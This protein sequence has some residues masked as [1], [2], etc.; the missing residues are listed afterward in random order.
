MLSWKYFSLTYIYLFWSH[1]LI[2]SFRKRGL[3]IKI[4]VIIDIDTLIHRAGNK[5]CQSCANIHLNLCCDFSDV[6]G[7][8]LKSLWYHCHYCRC[9]YDHY[10]YYYYCSVGYHHHK[11]T[12]QMPGGTEEERTSSV[13]QPFCWSKEEEEEKVRAGA[14][15]KQCG[16]EWSIPVA[17]LLRGLTSLPATPLP[18]TKCQCRES[19]TPPSWM[20]FCFTTLYC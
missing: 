14:S 7:S 2:G 4:D 9:C 8:E 10:Y 3:L 5:G 6:S 20:R 1:Q 17:V 16:G 13:A 19:H 18:L 15:W 11:K 12:F